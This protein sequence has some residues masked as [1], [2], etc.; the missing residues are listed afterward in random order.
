VVYT[1]NNS[2]IFLTNYADHQAINTIDILTGKL[3]SSIKLPAGNVFQALAV[4][5]LNNLL[6]TGCKGE[7]IIMKNNGIS[8]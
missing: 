8:F 4:D 5:R 3:L 2:V 6:L 1:R 7:I